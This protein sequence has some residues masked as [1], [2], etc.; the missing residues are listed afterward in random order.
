MNL[1]ETEISAQ[2][3]AFF[4]LNEMGSNVN[5]QQQDSDSQCENSMICQILREI[6][7]CI[8]SYRND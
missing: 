2:N 1:R 6:N 8:I 4:D 3:R 5:T 7:F